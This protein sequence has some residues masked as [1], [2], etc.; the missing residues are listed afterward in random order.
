MPKPFDLNL[1]RSLDALLQEE[2]VTR[3]AA[4]L[5]VTQ[6]TMSGSLSRLRDHFGDPILV[7]V[8]RRL[9]LTPLGRSLLQPVREAILRADFA[10]ETQP[11]FE[12]RHAVREF[13]LAM[14]DYATL[15]FLPHFLRRLAKQAPGISIRVRSIS[16]DNLREIVSGEL[17]MCLTAGDWNL[18]PNFK[19]SDVIRSVSVFHDDFVCVVDERHP[20]AGAGITME[21]YLAA[22]HNA[23]EFGPGTHAVVESAWAAARLSLKVAVTAPNFAS[24]LFML[25]HTDLVATTQRKLAAVLA[26]ALGLQMIECPFAINELQEVLIWHARNDEAPA[27]KFLRD[28]MSEAAKD[29]ASTHENLNNSHQ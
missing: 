21:D 4:R 26:P 18:Y 13:T 14:S 2:N 1:L 25:P 3:A 23:V 7:R 20:L 8:G 5:N 6:Q 11:H 16:P 17:D 15:V 19:P 28:V 9:R 10:L 22:N 29:L 24:Q 12:P 27:H